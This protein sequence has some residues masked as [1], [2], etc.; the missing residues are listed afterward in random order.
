MAVTNIPDN[1]TNGDVIKTLFPNATKMVELQ[2][3]EVEDGN[4]D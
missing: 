1:A 2:E 3:S 4:D